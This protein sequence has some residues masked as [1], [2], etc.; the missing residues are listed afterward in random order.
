MSKEGA[1]LSK[2]IDAV[3]MMEQPVAYKDYINRKAK[4]D[5]EFDKD[6]ID[7][8]SHD[9]HEVGMAQSQM[10]R[11]MGYAKD[12]YSM[13]E[14]VSEKEGIEGWVAAKLTKA[15]D[16]LGMV[17]HY[18]EHEVARADMA[19][20]D[21]NEEAPPGREKQV[22]A[23]KKEFGKSGAYAL[24]WAQHNKH[25]KPSKESIGES[26]MTDK[27]KEKL[28]E[29]IRIQT[30]SLED[31]IA[32]MT[33]L[34]NAGIDPQ[35]MSIQNQ[36]SMDTP[37]PDMKPDMPHDHD[38]MTHS[39]PGGDQPHDH[40]DEMPKDEPEAEAYDNAPDEKFL[41]KDD[42]ELKR[43][44]VPNSKMGPSAATRGDNP[45]PEDEA[46]EEA[47][48]KP[49]YIDIDKDGDKKEPMKKA[50]KDKE[51][52]KEEIDAIA[53]QLNKDYEMFKNEK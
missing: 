47:K 49:D 43:N 16:Y 10:F 30:D 41:D 17:K 26:T 2:F 44:K 42:Y 20:E 48:A 51:K 23:L 12:I 4:E 53:E 52:M 37:A 46:V 18:I 15:S 31:S 34:K 22:K 29:G 40:D 9:D 3:N 19:G 39:H 5:S 1:L 8:P 7:E 24:A 11:A 14:R 38:G 25:G 33:I 50:A 32:L 13:L 21:V 28:N 36:P 35:Q 27:N 45:L 6:K